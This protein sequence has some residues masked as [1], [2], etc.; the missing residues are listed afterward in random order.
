MFQKNNIRHLVD[1]YFIYTEGYI[2][3]QVDIDLGLWFIP[4]HIII[5]N[6][7]KVQRED[8]N[9]YYMTQYAVFEG[10]YAKYFIIETNSNRNASA[11]STT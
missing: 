5:W 3:R 4:L 7:D 6:G 1:K 9:K 8:I 10:N 2:R 11:V